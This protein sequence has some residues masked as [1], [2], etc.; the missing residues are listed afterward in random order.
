MFAQ[1]LN[2]LVPLPGHMPSPGELLKPSLASE[3]PC[4]HLTS[5]PGQ[6]CLKPASGL[7]FYGPFMPQGPR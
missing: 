3:G 4:P 6:A 7:S 1:R 2:P 5:Q